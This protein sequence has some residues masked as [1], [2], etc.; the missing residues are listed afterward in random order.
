[1]GNTSVTR[2][3]QLNAQRSRAHRGWPRLLWPGM[4]INCIGAASILFLIFCAR[5]SE[6]ELQANRLQ[7]QV[8]EQ[9]AA[10]KQLWR[11]V[12]QLRD[13]AELRRFAALQGMLFAPADA[14]DVTLPPLPPEQWAISPVS[15]RPAALAP[16]RRPVG[17]EQEIAA[18]RGQPFGRGW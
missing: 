12:S 6:L 17:A 10:Q 3:L 9:L 2:S 14:D 5:V 15:L 11:R 16:Q 4:L 1:M 8:D 18:R 7:R 13:R